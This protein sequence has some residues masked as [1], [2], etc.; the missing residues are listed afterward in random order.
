MAWA[1]CWAVSGLFGAV[2]ELSQ[3][4][5]GLLESWVVS[6]GQAFLFPMG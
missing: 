6:G 2:A 5:S 4:M 1:I 3:T